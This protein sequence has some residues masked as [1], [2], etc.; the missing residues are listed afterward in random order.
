[1]ESRIGIVVVGSEKV[2]VVGE[3]QIFTR[4]RV[5]KERP[6]QKR[7]QSAIDGWDKEKSSHINLV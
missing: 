1:M 3:E 4:D 2:F 6:P 5:A 7:K